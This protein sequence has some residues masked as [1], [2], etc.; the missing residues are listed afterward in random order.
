MAIQ[1]HTVN[2]GSGTLLKIYAEPAN[3]NYFVDGLTPDAQQGPSNIQVNAGGGSRRKYPG[4]PSVSYS[5]TSRE[6]LV[7][8]SRSSGSAL[9]GKPFVLR[10]HG[11]EEYNEKRQFTFV[12]RVIDLHAYLRQNAS[13]PCFLHTNTGARYLIKDIED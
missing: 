7:D 5:G 1:A 11:N 9:P 3:I 10:E 4:G 2:T 6:V 12:G 8:P 13:V